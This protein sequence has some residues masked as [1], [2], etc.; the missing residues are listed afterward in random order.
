[1]GAYDHQ[2]VPFELVVEALQPNRS[3][4]HS[5]LFQAMIAFENAP[6]EGEF[7][8]SGVTLSSGERKKS[9]EQVQEQSKF[10]V[11]L[12]LQEVD[13]DEGRLILGGMTYAS[14]LFDKA[15][16]VRWMGYF[17]TLLT[18][19]GRFQRYSDDVSEG[20]THP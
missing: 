18:I 16:M 15:T 20:K 1:L 17:E 7:E 2:D 6:H 5:P 9:T 13:S 11:L 10:D 14:E 3:L 8:L 12:S 19:A 4:S